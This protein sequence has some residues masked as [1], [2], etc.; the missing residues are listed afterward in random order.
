MAS[1]RFKWTAAGSTVAAIGLAFVGYNLI[2]AQGQGVL[3]QEPLA[4]K[5]NATPSFIMAVDDSGSMVFQTQFP[6]RDGEGCWNTTRRSFFDANGQLYQSGACDYFF[7]TPGPRINNYYG[8]PPLDSLGFAR[9][10]AYNPSYYDPTIKYERWIAGPNKPE[11]AKVVDPTSAPTDPRANFSIGNINLIS[12]YYSTSLNDTF[13]MQTGMVVQAGTTIRNYNTGR[14]TRFDREGTWT[15]GD[16]RASIAFWPATF[17]TPYTSDDDARPL[18]AGVAGVYDGA[19]RIKVSNACGTGCTM[20]KY[21]LTG[22]NAAS[23]NFANWFTYYG[24]RNRAMIAGMT[25]SMEGVTDLNVGYFRINQNGSYDSGTNASKRLT[26]RKMTADTDKTLLYTDMLALTASGG[27]PNRQAVNAAALQFTRT[28]ADAPI[29]SSCQKNAV[30]LFT[31][32][33]S[34]GGGPT[35]GNNDQN[36]GAPFNDSYSNTM[37]DIVSRFYNNNGGQP[38][39]RPDLAAGMVPVPE[40]CGNGDKSLDC[41]T[42]L[43]LN[44]YGVTLGAR[45][46]LFNPDLDQNAY[47]DA[48]IY[49]NWPPREDDERSTVDDIWH[50]AVNTRGEYINARTPVD[51]TNAMSRVLQAVGSGG[52]PASGTGASGARIGVGSITAGSEYTIKNE[53][54]DW[55]STLDAVRLSIDPVSRALVQTDF[56]EASANLQS[57]GSRRIFFTRGG[58]AREFTSG[59]VSLTDLCTKTAA[60]SSMLQCSDMATLPGITN[61][62]AVS[63]LRGDVSR[64]KRNGGGFRDRSTRLGDIINSTPVITSPIDDFGYRGLGGTLASSYATYLANKSSNGQYM[65]YAGANDG[66]L[67]A[68]NGGMNGA[69]EVVAGGGTEAF[70]YIPSTSLGH[71]GNL[72]IPYDVTSTVG[73]KFKHKYF[74]DGQIAVGDTY[75]GGNWRT[76]LVGASGAGGRSVFGLDVTHGTTFAAA[77]RLW[78][79]SDIDTNL[80]QAVRDNIGFV[81][82]KPV[83]VP[84]LE[85]GNPTWKAIFGNGFNSASGKA[86]LF[87]VDIATGS[88]R[89]IEAVE[90]GTGVPTGSN[91]L[92]SIVV[93]DRWG[94][95]GQNTRTRDGYSDTVYGTDQKGAVWKFDLRATGN[96]SIPLFTTLPSTSDGVRVRQPITGGITA[97]TGTNGGVMLYFGTG[98]FSFEND[99]NDDSLQSL[100]G[101]NDLVNGAITTTLTRANL[102]G[103]TANIVGNLRTLTAGTPPANSRGWYI[104]LAFRERFVGNPSLSNGML[105]M[106]TYIP[107]DKR[108]ASTSCAVPGDNWL[109]GLQPLTGA[110]AL[111]RASLGSPTGTGFATGT[112]GFKS[113]SQ[114]GSPITNANPFALPRQAPPALGAGGGG[115]PPPSVP[116]STCVG[117]IQFG[118]DTLYIPY[119]CGRQSWR[120]IQ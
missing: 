86:V 8:V 113:S 5:T 30:M 68:F 103:S 40:A 61:A 19:T 107:R 42:N 26:M 108:N 92:A 52:A 70:A 25:R 66:M 53:G 112:A 81:L 120:Q 90:T 115:E 24:N 91:G 15:D 69:G 39:L 110:G 12:S 118:P 47:T 37:A 67:H 74:V 65:V 29:S 41:Q 31:D 72:L 43:H 23:Q 48:S 33:F 98:S 36:M 58:T 87:V 35:V 28:D 18:L 106:P 17:Y 88:A 2:A 64:E 11:F 50:A 10:A 109:F 55:S 46:N 102:S 34:N 38:P 97:G 82:G 75:Y 95:T 114:G 44:F 104:D 63:Y 116:N 96:L 21:T 94:G 100:Y 45:G 20:W 22:N 105:S 27:T 3:A 6:G 9:S 56:W 83:I 84:V 54:T 71:M 93:I 57:A 78:E 89:M 79:I 59:N 80:P 111:G 32:G 77:S 4:S 14:E 16:A 119:P 62:T 73:Q 99:P 7:V 101:V 60:N 51:I 49:G 76:T 85:G 1:R 13:R 117:G